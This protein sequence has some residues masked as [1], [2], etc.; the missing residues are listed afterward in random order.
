MWVTLIA[1]A[2]AASVCLSEVNLASQIKA[3]RD[4][5]HS[6]IAEFTAPRNATSHDRSE[7][8]PTRNAQKNYNRK[9]FDPDA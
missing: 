7:A 4:T 3:V 2:L 6:P 5:G 8:T 1:T 9:D